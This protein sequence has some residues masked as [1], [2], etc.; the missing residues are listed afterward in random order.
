MLRLS[1]PKKYLYWGGLE[2]PAG[3]TSIGWLWTLWLL[4]QSSLAISLRL[5]RKAAATSTL[6]KSVDWSSIGHQHAAEMEQRRNVEENYSLVARSVI[7]EYCLIIEFY[8][9]ASEMSKMD[10]HIR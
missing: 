2:F 1:S 3:W 6:T 5:D 7:R 4:V 9:H 8:I 10:R